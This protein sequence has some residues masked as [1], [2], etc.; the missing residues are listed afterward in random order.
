VQQLMEENHLRWDSLGEFL[1]LA[2]SLED[3]ARKHD[4]AKAKVIAAALDKANGAFLNNNKSP[5]RKVG[6]L[7]TRGSHFYLAMYWAQAL[8][9]QDDDAELK[10]LFTP[11]AQALAGN[12]TKIV[13]ELNSV[14]GKSVDLGGYY[15]PDKVKTAEVM[16]PSA[17]L[18]AIIDGLVGR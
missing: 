4:N 3:F 11:V 7:D 5:S 17:S 8:A 18:N 13:A 15:C 2:V 9:E 10:A 6:E 14:Q 12:E 16:R 1:A